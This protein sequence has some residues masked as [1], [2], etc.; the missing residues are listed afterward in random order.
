MTAKQFWVATALSTSSSLLVIGAIA[1]MAPHAAKPAGPTPAR[2]PAP[3]PMPAGPAPRPNS[4]VAIAAQ[5]AKL[6]LS[7]GRAATFAFSVSHGSLTCVAAIG[8]DEVLGYALIRVSDPE[9]P[10]PGPVPSP[11]Q[12]APTPAPA[13]VP[14]AHNLRV[15]F[16]YDPLVLTSLP[17]TQQA[18]LTSPA[19]RSYLDKHCPLESGCASGQCPLTAG[20]TPSYRFLPAHA[21]VSRLTPVWQQTAASAD[22]KPV[23]W[24]IAVNEAGQTVIDQAWPAGVDETLTLLRR[25]GGP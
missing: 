16:T 18:I 1:L 2:T 22:A 12:P 9:P 19:V 8:L 14:V 6:A 7:D 11:T 21:D 15:L 10:Q 13:P 4:P 3:I 23:P 5:K 25:F 20:K 24:I 17:A